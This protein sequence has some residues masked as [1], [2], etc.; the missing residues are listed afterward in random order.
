MGNYPFGPP[1][2]TLIEYLAPSGDT[3]GVTD[4]PR[5]QAA[6]N[7]GKAVNLT[8][9][10][11]WVNQVL[12]IPGYAA[13]YGAGI[14]LTTIKMAAG[15]NLAAV[16]ASAG[17]TAS[18]NTTSVEPADIRDVTFDANSANQTGGA[19]HGLVL[20]TNYSYIEDCAFNNTLGDGFRFDYYGANGSTAIG[21]SAVENRV[22]RCQARFNG[23]TGINI[24]D[25]SNNAFTD[26]FIG[27][28]ITQSSG[29]YGINVDAGAGWV[30]RGNHVYT[31]AKSGIVVG[32][33][34]MTGVVGNY[35]EDFGV[36]SVQ[37][38]Y[39]AIDLSASYYV[40]DFGAGS[41]ISGNRVNLNNAPAN[42][43]SVL[44]AIQTGAVSGGQA[45]VTITDNVC[46][47]LDNTYPAN[48]SA[49][50]PFNQSSTA[51][52][53]AVITGNIIT[54][55]WGGGKIAPNANGGTMNITGLNSTGSNSS[56]S[57]P[58]LTALGAVSGTA[59]QLS[60]LTRDYMVYLEATTAGTA[61]SISIG[62][63]SAASAVT[64]LSSVSVS[65]GDLYSF[66]LPAG[67][68]FKWTG[69]TTAIGNQNAVGC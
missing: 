26:G 10:T 29:V 53:N 50:V 37:G 47:A 25:S 24:H 16:A 12:Q 35:I 34:Y 56:G 21:N 45:N 14:Y 19:G 15:A 63:T 48:Y 33:A 66:R 8:A 22:F 58:V 44:T 38:F 31:T 39:G 2:D 40:N 4:T 28:C 64:V 17:W 51:T 65:V 57:A 67:W 3:T 18:T 41:V 54:G 43:S 60:D 6:L 27:D 62:P 36:G 20:Q 7:S 11:F 1:G 32:T 23:G 42:A 30:I 61:T 52:T 49:I 13:M 9:G 55:H 68:Y 69:T 59:I 46:S 5:I